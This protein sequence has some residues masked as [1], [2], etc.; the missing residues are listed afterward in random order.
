MMWECAEKAFRWNFDT[1]D[2]LLDNKEWDAAFHGLHIIDFANHVHLD[3]FA[4]DNPNRE[5][6][7][8]YFE[9]YYDLADEYVGRALKWL[10]EGVSII[11]ASDHGGLMKYPG[12]AA[13]DIGDAWGMTTG[14]MSALGYTKTKV[15]N[16]KFTIDWENTRAISQ[17]S[18]YIYVNLKGRDPQGIV[19]PEEYD[20]LVT[21]I[22]SDLY[23]YRDP[24]HGE[25][26]FSAA[27]RRNEMAVLGLSD[28]CA[29]NLGDI[30][31]IL[32]PKFARDQGNSY[33]NTEIMGTSLQCI[34]MMAGEGIKEDYIIHRDV[35]EVDLVPTLC[36]LAGVEPP[37]GVE[38]GVLYQALK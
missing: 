15:E 38:G 10:D 1:I 19:E 6:F 16:G 37:N 5:L 4:Q 30:F 34:F 28:L 7:V 11:I 29:E 24:V 12:Y 17:R 35:Q 8:E 32:E 25:R 36:H 2:Y 23:S 21:Q 18:S 20:D 22:I 9:K 31:F 26:V 33:S 13:P 14:V 3:S 27:F